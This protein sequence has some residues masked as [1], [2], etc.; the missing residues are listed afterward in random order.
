MKRP[1]EADHYL[2]PTTPAPERHAYQVGYETGYNEATRCELARIAEL[3]AQ[4]A[5]VR[6]LADEWERR[7][8]EAAATAAPSGVYRAG[9]IGACAAEL[10]EHLGGTCE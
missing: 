3:E 10:R 4:L 7:A 1:E 6:E 9:A 2:E 8:E 5:S